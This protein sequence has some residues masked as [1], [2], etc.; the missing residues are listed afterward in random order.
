MLFRSTPVRNALAHLVQEK[1]IRSIPHH[2]F[3]IAPLTLDDVQQVFALR[4][5]LESA[6]V[7]LAAGHVDAARLRRL[8]QL[9][10]PLAKRPDNKASRIEHLAADREFHLAIAEA[11]GNPFLA[12]DVAHLLDVSERMFHLAILIRGTCELHHLHRDVIDALMASDGDA[13]RKITVEQLLY[14]QREIIDALIQSRSVRATHVVAEGAAAV[15]S[16]VQI[17]LVRARP[18]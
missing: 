3:E 17:D 15:R 6:A 18:A 12:E 9:C 8:D 2:G 14:A 4:V 7:Q 11:A 16:I 13:A 5:I 10:A 1:L